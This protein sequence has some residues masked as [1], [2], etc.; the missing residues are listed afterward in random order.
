MEFTEEQK[1]RLIESILSTH[2]GD[3]LDPTTRNNIMK[4][5]NNTL[6]PECKMYD[7][8]TSSE[9]DNLIINFQV[10]FKDGTKQ[11]ISLYTGNIV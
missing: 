2:V 4:Q 7:M 3:Q 11:M 6:Y 5:I 9:T 10:E 1:H 8:T